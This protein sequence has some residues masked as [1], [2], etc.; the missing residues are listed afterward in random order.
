MVG[1]AASGWLF[2]QLYI[3]KKMVSMSLLVAARVYGVKRM[4]RRSLELNNRLL[5]RDGGLHGPVRTQLR[6]TAD[7]TLAVNDKLWRAWLAIR[8]RDGTAGAPGGAAAP[9][10]K[11]PPHAQSPPP[12]PPPHPGANS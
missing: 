9:Q 1:P 2:V 10:P 3:A 11:P 8:G 4:Y 6:N 7:A 12:P 5:S